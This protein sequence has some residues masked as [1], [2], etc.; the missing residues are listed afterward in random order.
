MGHPPL[1]FLRALLGGLVPFLC[2]APHATAQAGGTPLWP[3]LSRFDFDVY[4]VDLEGWHGRLRAELTEVVG[5]HADLYL[6]RGAPPTLGIWDFASTTPGTSDESLVVDAGTS[7]AL[8]NGPWFLGVFRPTGTAYDIDWFLDVL[9]SSHPGLGANPFDDGQDGAA[10]FSFRTWAPNADGAF[11]V[12]DFNGWSDTATPMTSEGDGN[13][14]VDVR[15][16]SAGSRYRY[17]LHNASQ[18]LWRNDPRAREVTS[19]VGDSIA[20]DPG[21]FDWGGGSF[22][23]PAWNDIVL[24]EL[25]V[26]T[27][28]EHVAGLPAGFAE[29][30]DRLPYLADLGVNAIEL[31]PVCEFPGDFSWGYNYS[32]PFAVEQAYGGLDDLKLFVRACHESGIAVLGDVLYNHWGPSDMDLWRYDGWSTGPWGGIYFYN[33]SCNGPTPWGDTR[34]DFGRGEVRQYIRDN[35]MMWLEECRFDGLR[36]DST[37][38]IRMGNCGDI[39]EG[40]SLLQWCNDE[41]D[42]SQPWK[43]M[44]AEDMYDAPNE[45]ITKDTGAG[46]AGFDM[47]WDAMFVHP[48]RAAVETVWDDDRDMWAVRNAITQ[49]YNGDAF[50]RVIYTESH[51]EV[52]NGR[53]RVPEE[54]WPGNADSWYS[55][56]RSTLASTL[57]L[58]SPGVPMLFMGQEFLEDGWFHDDDPLDWDR[59]ALFPGIHSLYRDLIHLRRDFW[60]TTRGLKGQHTNVHHVNDSN[61]MIAFHRWD[62]GGAGDDVIVVCNFRDQAWSDYTIG[63][64]AEGL[65]RVRFDSDWPG[66][67]PGYGGWPTH[68]VWASGTPYDGMPAS[69][70]L[71]IGP[72]TALIFSR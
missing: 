71:S 20:V 27:F 16:L 7:P 52:A 44:V 21:A 64:P 58:T 68:D 72:Y 37:S 28:N 19:S 11:L 17:V 54:I 48:V 1:S 61:K 67:D 6:R 56:K 59:L 55:K 35:V 36:L 51:D 70:S 45:W 8:S 31:M 65:W 50:Q 49:H 42:G 9:P 39:P 22:E 12:G 66:Y 40:W 15:E 29:A 18:E 14:S 63:F 2:L 41:V 4:Q 24:Y 30:I 53:Q 10:G 5:P 26:G 34:P 3:R 69:G 47:Q 32:H 33:D 23:M 13:F 43:L 62:Q 46:G 60:G 25:H 57:V 38:N